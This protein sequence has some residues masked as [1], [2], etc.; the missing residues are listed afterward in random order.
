MS[1]M[2]PVH[3][4]LTREEFYV[5]GAASIFK[6]HPELIEM[7]ENDLTRS[8]TPNSDNVTPEFYQLFLG[9]SRQG[10][11]IHCALTINLFRQISGRKKWYFIPPSQTPYLR[12]KVYANGFSATSKTIQPHN[13]K[14]GS[15]WFNKLKRYTVTLEPGDLLLNPPWWWHG[16]ENL[17]GEELVVGVATRFIAGPRRVL[18]V[19]PF[20]TALAI[21]RLLTSKTGVKT[22]GAQDPEAY[23][24]G[25]IANRTETDQ[26]LILDAR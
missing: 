9:H 26:Q 16:V 8:I 19:D 2:L 4:A 5:A 1:C 21:S 11:T 3:E 25:L 13:G 17:P 23:E 20:K 12:A 18:S 22:R 6:H 7:V 24:Q 14:A 10:T 15:P